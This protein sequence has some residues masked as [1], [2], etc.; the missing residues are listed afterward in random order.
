M[1]SS[2]A[3]AALLIVGSMLLLL[4]AG[5]H[6][7]RHTNF[8]VR[9]QLRQ[10]SQHDQTIIEVNVRRLGEQ[11]QPSENIVE[12]DIASYGAV[13]DGKQDDTPAFQKAWTAA[14]SSSQP[15]TLLVPKEKTYLVNPITFSGKCNSS[16]ITF[17][18]EGKLVAPSRSSWPAENTRPRW[19]VFD[20][21]NGL[22]VTG[23][24]TIDGNGE[25]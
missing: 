22:T 6:A 5:A 25:M 4:P 7:D 1:A 11:S 16:S 8:P 18:L 19:I 2:R 23:G 20:N 9:R 17:R 10:R 12:V 15:A 13:G 21:V 24:G 3:L 14:C